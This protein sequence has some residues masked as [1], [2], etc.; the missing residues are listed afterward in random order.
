MRVWLYKQDD[1]VKVM[2]ESVKNIY[3]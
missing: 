1:G 2:D 3:R